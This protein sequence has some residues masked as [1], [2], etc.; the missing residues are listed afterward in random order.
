MSAFSPRTLVVL[1]IFLV[2]IAGVVAFVRAPAEDTVVQSATVSQETPPSV[3]ESVTP[4]RG[5]E[6]TGPHI[7][8]DVGEAAFNHFGLSEKDFVTIKNAGFDVIEGN[9]DICASDEDV[10]YFLDNARRVG[11]KVILNAGS[12]EAEWGY[13]C[14]EKYTS[15]QKPVWQREKVRQ[16]VEKW[17]DHPALYLW[18]TSNEDGGTLPFGTGGTM[19]D[20]NWETKFA[21]STK[22]LQQAYRDVKSFDSSHQVMIRMNG[23]YFYDNADNFF[24]LGNSFGKNVADIVMIN[25]Y[26]NVDEYFPDFVSTVLSRA[27]RSIY[28]I[29]PKVKIIPS[30]GVWSEP[31]VWFKP[32]IEHLT[33]DYNQA[34]KAEN[35]VGIAFFKYG[36]SAGNDWLLPDPVR[37]SPVL[38]QTISEL[39]KRP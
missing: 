38:W 13:A 35:L 19:P 7:L 22:Q 36:A 20:P 37:G 9:F 8:K 32:T 3:L 30:L 11:L 31:P 25:A 29:D 12:G 21:L 16:W 6:S 10:Q 39:I 14:D 28:A 34:Q 15:D 33:N 5:G 2:A 4:D 1:V 18:D 24:R 17:K 27:A 26:S 23:W